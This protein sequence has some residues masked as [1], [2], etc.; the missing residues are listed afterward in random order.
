M[1]RLTGLII[2]TRGDDV[3]CVSQS[4]D[5]GETWS[6]WINLHRSDGRFDHAL[7]STDAIFKSED[8]AVSKMEEIVK[9]AR[10]M[11]LTGDFGGRNEKERSET[12]LAARLEI[13]KATAEL[14]LSDVLDDNYVI[15]GRLDKMSRYIEQAKSE[16][17]N[18]REASG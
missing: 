17:R 12:R 16:L 1:T 13:I 3:H 9:E 10:N 7:M 11:D 5:G 2:Q 14:V 6:G 8:E 18:F 4:L 15:D